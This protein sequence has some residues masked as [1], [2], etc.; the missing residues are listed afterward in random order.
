VLPV[1]Q[2]GTFAVLWVVQFIVLDRVIFHPMRE[3]DPR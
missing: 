2:A 1:V 3:L